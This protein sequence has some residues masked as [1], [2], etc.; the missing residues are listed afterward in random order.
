MRRISENER[1][2]IAIVALLLAHLLAAIV[3]PCDGGCSL[4]EELAIYGR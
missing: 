2:F 1:I 3:E 4:K